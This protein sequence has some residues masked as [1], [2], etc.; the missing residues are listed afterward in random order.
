MGAVDKEKLTI[1]DFLF[2]PKG[3]IVACPQG[4]APAKV[5]KRKKI[6]IAFS[7]T[8]C[9]IRLPFTFAVFCLDKKTAK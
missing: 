5:K 9:H 6:S 1:A 3:E 4:N 8:N 7:S 2:S